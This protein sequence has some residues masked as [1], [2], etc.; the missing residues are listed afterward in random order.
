LCSEFIEDSHSA[1]PVVK[2]ESEYIPMFHPDDVNGRCA[3][4]ADTKVT[5]PDAQLI[6]NE[7]TRVFKQ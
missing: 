7:F 3:E 1:V 2:L 6:G 4:S 5:A